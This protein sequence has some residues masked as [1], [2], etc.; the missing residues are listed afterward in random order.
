MLILFDNK[1]KISSHK[2][3]IKNSDLINKY[4]SFL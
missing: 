1:F 3:F 4:L 2:K